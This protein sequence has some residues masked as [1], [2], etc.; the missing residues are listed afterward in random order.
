MGGACGSES[1]MESGGAQ[2]LPSVDMK[3]KDVYERFELSL[4]FNKILIK[5]FQSKV[6]AAQK[7]CGN[8][9]F[10]TVES[11]KKHFTTPAWISLG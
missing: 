11:L 10:V 4:P 2:D 6:Y 5:D 3:G 9:D 8:K 7:D 1:K